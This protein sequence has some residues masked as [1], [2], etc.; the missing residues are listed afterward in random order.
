[1]YILVHKI[2]LI[3]NHNISNFLVCRLPRSA[4]LFA[5]TYCEHVCAD[6]RAHVCADRRAHVCADGRAHVFANRRAHVCANRRAHD[7]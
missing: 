3:Y 6:R 2:S 5:P 1:M 4:D 7:A